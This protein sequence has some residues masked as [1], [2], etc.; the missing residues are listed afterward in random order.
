M[1]A[2]TGRKRQFADGEDVLRSG[3]DVFQCWWSGS[4][5]DA[6][7]QW[8]VFDY[9]LMGTRELIIKKVSFS[10]TQREKEQFQHWSFVKVVIVSV[11]RCCCTGLALF[12]KHQRIIKCCI[13]WFSFVGK[14]KKKKKTGMCQKYTVIVVI[15]QTAF[16]VF[17]HQW[18]LRWFLQ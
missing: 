18:L 4:E 3:L 1:E 14:Q 11:K 7:T 12:G 5:R 6:T 8:E 2:K 16:R 17:F 13:W 10:A 9:Q 15:S